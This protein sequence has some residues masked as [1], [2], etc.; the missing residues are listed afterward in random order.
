MACW[1]R[2]GAD[3]R[4][5]CGRC[6]LPLPEGAL[7]SDPAAGACLRCVTHPNP[8][9]RVVAAVTYD[10]HAR[11]FLLR[12]KNGH[13][14]ELFTPLSGQLAAAIAAAR[15]AD[16]IDGV[17][18][19]PSSL[20]ARWRRGFDPAREIAARLSRAFA[21]P[22]WSGTLVGRRPWEAPMKRLSAPARLRGAR[23]K[24]AARRTLRGM[25]VLLVDDVL[26]TGAT[27]SACAEALRGAGAREVRVAVWARTPHRRSFAAST[28]NPL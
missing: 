12:A 17:V 28:Q 9:D 22:L 27:A 1:A 20:F 4:R 3:T 18:P 24:F 11:R 13:R 6:A 2:L 21:L 19:V 8:F 23:E 5:R 14:P 25:S 10:D 15:L 7:E 26:T 16:G